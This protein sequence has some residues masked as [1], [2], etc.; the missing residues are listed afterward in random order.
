MGSL[1]I[2]P[3]Q[4]KSTTVFPTEDNGQRLGRLAFST[5]RS[6]VLRLQVAHVEVHPCDAQTL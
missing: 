5:G 1:Y 3:S 2:L 4:W 6:A